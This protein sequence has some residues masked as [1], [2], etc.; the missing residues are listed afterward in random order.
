MS[1]DVRLL[2][3][4]L[5]SEDAYPEISVHEQIAERVSHDDLN[6]FDLLFL[7]D[8]LVHEWLFHVDV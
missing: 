5:D 3:S 2:L 8:L 7:D 4:P 6:L 1:R